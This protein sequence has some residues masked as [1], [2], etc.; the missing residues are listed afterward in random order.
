M[1]AAGFAGALMGLAPLALAQQDPAGRELGPVPSRPMAWEFNWTP[2]RAPDGTPI[3]LLGGGVMVA[4]NEDWGLGPTVYG[5]AKGNLGGLFVYGLTAQRRWRL[6]G[7]SHVAASLFAGGGGGRSSD[8][9]RFGG[10]LMLRPELSVRTE[11]GRWYAGVGVSHLRFTGGNLRGSQ[12]SLSFGRMGLFD[13]LQLADGDAGGRLGM[14]AGF[15]FDEVS[16]IST[17]YKPS[18]GRRTRSGRA[19]SDRTVVL[20]ADLRQYFTPG[21]WLGLEA[22]GAAKGGIDGYM[23]VLAA[24]GQDWELGSSGIRLGGHLGV[25]LAGGGD[26]DTGSGWIW[27]GGPS[28]RWQLKSGPAF[29]LEAGKA[30]TRGTFNAPYLRASLSMPL[31]PLARRGEPDALLGGQAREQVLYASV[32]RLSRVGFKDG[33]REGMT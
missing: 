6:G 14:R 27:R 18:A 5:A 31:E 10:G 23:E 28:L 13:G 22:S 17:V 2:M 7:S 30:W 11:F 24:A 15:G 20:G 19:M 3:G 26:V 8:S 25:G 1:S 33:G 12:V 32:Q 16:L 21:S 29:R 4:V 9:L